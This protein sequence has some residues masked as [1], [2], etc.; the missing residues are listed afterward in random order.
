MF[1]IMGVK[2]ICP[3][4]HDILYTKY[5]FHCH[6]AAVIKLIE[7]LVVDLKGILRRRW[8]KEEDEQ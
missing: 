2:C 5:S 8:E 6:G 3:N 4:Q 1:R 7:D